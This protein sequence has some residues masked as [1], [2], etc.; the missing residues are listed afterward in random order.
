MGKYCDGDETY[1]EILKDLHIFFP[2]EYEKMVSRMLTLCMCVP[3]IR[4]GWMYSY[5]VFM[6]ISI[7]GWYMVN[8][9][10]VAPEIGTLWKNPKNE[11]Q[12]LSD[13][14]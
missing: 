10:T 2:C 11:W 8:M 5:S 3:L 7:I 13:F 4:F 12:F 1:L 14:A 6:N 9:N